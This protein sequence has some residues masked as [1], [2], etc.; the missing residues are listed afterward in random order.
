MNAEQRYY[1]LQDEIQAIERRTGL[2]LADQSVDMENAGVPRGDLVF[3]ERCYSAAM[4]AAELRAEEAGEN[5]S[6]LIGWTN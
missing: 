5:F 1:A 4:V 3:F 2:Y 6:D